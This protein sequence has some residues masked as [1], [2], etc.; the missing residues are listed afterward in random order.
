MHSTLTA[1]GH[2]TAAS[3]EQHIII[4]V[5][6]HNI[7]NTRQAERSAATRS[8]YSIIKTMRD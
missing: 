4:I 3:V 1:A 8:V 2:G 6:Q 7:T 5:R